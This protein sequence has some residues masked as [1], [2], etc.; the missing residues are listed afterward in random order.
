[1]AQNESRIIRSWS[2]LAFAQTFGGDVAV[3]T[4]KGQDGKEFQAVAFNNGSKR[5]FVDFGESLQPGLSLE[6]IV[7][8]VNDLQVVELQTTPEVLARRQAKAATTG[9][10]VQLETYKLCKVGESSWKSVNL[11][12]AIAH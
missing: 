7:A 3:G 11:F 12:A 4:C 1:M 6:E 2:L 10:P 5:T 8:S 9:K